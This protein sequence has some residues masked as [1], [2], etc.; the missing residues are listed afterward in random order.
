MGKF[1]I[2]RCSR[3]SFC[4]D[5]NRS[6]SYFVENGDHPLHEDY[7]YRLLRQ[8]SVFRICRI[9][10][11]EVTACCKWSYIVI[12]VQFAHVSFKHGLFYLKIRAFVYYIPYIPRNRRLRWQITRRIDDTAVCI[13]C[14]LVS[15]DSYPRFY[16][17]HIFFNSIKLIRSIKRRKRSIL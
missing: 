8:L 16:T 7:F 11:I 1:V 12:C 5:G 9:F 6:S 10:D 14:S 17:W 2:L 15:N 13:Q 3:V 4:R